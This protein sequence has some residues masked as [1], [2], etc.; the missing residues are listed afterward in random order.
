[1]GFII[2]D[3]RESIG[4]SCGEQNNEATMSKYWRSLCVMK[5]LEKNALSKFSTSMERR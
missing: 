4:E 1:M 3:N 2:Q 5:A